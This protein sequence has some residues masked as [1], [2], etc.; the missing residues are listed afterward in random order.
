MYLIDDLSKKLATL[1][2]LL[3]A[4]LM[5]FMAVQIIDSTLDLELVS[6]AHARAAGSAGGAGSIGGA[7]SIGS[8][9]GIRRNS[10]GGYDSTGW[11]RIGD[12]YTELPQGCTRD[13][14]LGSNMFNCGDIYFKRAFRANKVSYVITGGPGIDPTLSGSS[15]RSHTIQ[16]R[17]LSRDDPSIDRSRTVTTDIERRRT[18]PRDDPSIN[19]S[20]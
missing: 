20:R 15:S 11:P 16:R 12:T 5:I 1:F 17:D 13:F 7:R 19:R 4:C 2:L 6:A 9:P 8:R 3:G 14:S 18:V 10:A